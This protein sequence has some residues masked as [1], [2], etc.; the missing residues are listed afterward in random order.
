MQAEKNPMANKQSFSN[1]TYAAEMD[2][3]ERELSAFIGAVT[4]LFGPEQARVSTEDWLDELTLMT[5]PSRSKEQ[6]LRAVTIAAA[7]RLANRVN[8][9]THPEIYSSAST[10]TK[11]SPIHRLIVPVRYFGCDAF[12]ASGSIH[13]R[14]QK[15]L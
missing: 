8:T 7:A 5:W 4:E 13:L 2:R 11:A 6:K 14:K 9:A 10:D 1:S 3:A 15:L 12:E